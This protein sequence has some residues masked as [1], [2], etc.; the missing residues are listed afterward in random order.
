MPEQPPAR[1]VQRLHAAIAADDEQPRG[2]AGDDFPAQPL[3]RLRASGHGL[4]ANAQLRER[5]LH[6]GRHEGGLGAGLVPPR[7]ICRAAAN[8]RS[9]VNARPGDD[10]AEGR[11][12]QK[13][14]EG[15]L[16]TCAL[17]RRRGTSATRR[18]PY[19]LATSAAS[20]SMVPNGTLVA[21]SARRVATSMIA[22]SPPIIRGQDERQDDQLDAEERPDHR[23]HLHVAEAHGFDLPQ[24]VPRLP[25]SPRAARRR[26][27]C[28]R[29]TSAAR[30]A[31]TRLQIRNRR[32]CRARVMTFGRIWCSRSM[33]KRTMSAQAKAR[34]TT[35][36]G[37]G[38]KTYQCSRKI[39]HVSA[40]TIG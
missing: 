13:E 1:R 17:H 12:Q 27:R 20:A 3:G 23:Q 6:G 14:D 35:S 8:R 34:R 11:R 10:D 40:S 39:A 16:W 9:T 30:E 21:I 32:R 33:A 24:P 2:Q 31:G 37:V 5:L 26:A 4:L 18:S 19:R 25:Q 38:P 7:D 15:G 29:A 22:T 36:S 28:P